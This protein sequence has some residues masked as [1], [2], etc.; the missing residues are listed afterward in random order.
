MLLGRA[1]CSPPR[2]IMLTAIL[3]LLL[4]YCT[5]RGMHHKTRGQLEMVTNELLRVHAHSKPV[6][7]E[8][9]ERQVKTPVAS[10][11]DDQST[12]N[13]FRFMLPS[14][15]VDENITC[16]PGGLNPRFTI[17]VHD[18]EIDQHV[19]GDII[20]YGTWE[21]HIMAKYVG[22]LDMYPGAHVLDV[23]AQLGQ[24]GL[25]AAVKGRKVI[26]IEAMPHNANHILHSIHKNGMSSRLC[27]DLFLLRNAA[28]HTSGLSYG[29]AAVNVENN[30][31]TAWEV[32][33]KGQTFEQAEKNTMSI[34]IDDLMPIMQDWTHVVVKMDIEGGEC[35]ALMGASK[36][37][38]SGKV[39]GLFME[40]GRI[41]MSQHCQ[42]IEQL[43]PLFRSGL[44]PRHLHGTPLS[45]DN[46]GSWPWDVVLER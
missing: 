29:V 38:A 46:A 25:Q 6:T 14:L 44:V 36:L 18:P 26:M 35:E 30:G 19:S 10:Q 20:K 27:R 45:T 28:S 39:V 16:V 17:C 5:E 41:P 7:K 21:P 11:C 23:G 32:K 4:M 42:I 43:Q 37:L 13:S 12:N 15:R 3:I 2:V 40:T 31:G 1:L 34:T 9:H 22:L 8:D 24:Y 33:P